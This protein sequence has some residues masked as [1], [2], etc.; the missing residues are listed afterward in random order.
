MPGFLHVKMDVGLV[1]IL[2]VF[3][4]TNSIPV[5]V[6]Q[7]ELGDA[8]PAEMLSDQARNVMCGIK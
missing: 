1:E 7:I 5:G 2:A 6:K 3:S 4:D 8:S